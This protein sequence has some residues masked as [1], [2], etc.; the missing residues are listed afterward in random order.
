MQLANFVGTWNVQLTAGTPF[1][2]GTT[3]D[4]QDNEGTPTVAFDPPVPSSELSATFVPEEDALEIVGIN[5]LSALRIGLY[6]DPDAQTGY[7]ALYGTG[8]AS[9]S[10]RV[11]Q[12]VAF[13]AVLA[14][15]TPEP[16]LSATAGTATAGA[17]KVRASSGSQFGVG[18]DIQL[19]VAPESAV[20]MVTSALGSALSP[21]TLVP[22]D[23]NSLVLRGETVSANGLRT[24]VQ[25]TVM[26]L[27]NRRRLC[28]I[29]VV[30]D[31]ESSGVWAADEVDP[32]PAV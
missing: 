9:S 6:T 5:N 25:C 22:V 32:S 21:I 29:A 26:T 30:G 4:I 3:I 14:K 1:G 13:T 16:P 8:L 7:R 2:Y 27:N 19:A 15:Q 17:F 12:S 31:P 18:S 28:G 23:G 24:I 20:F 10:G 11:E